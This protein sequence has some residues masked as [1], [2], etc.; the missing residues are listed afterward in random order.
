MEDADGT[1]AEAEGEGGFVK[2]GSFGTFMFSRREKA[3]QWISI[4]EI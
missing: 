1:S 2:L 4:I 3:E